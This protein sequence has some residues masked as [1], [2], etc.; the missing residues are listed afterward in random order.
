MYSYTLSLTLALDG[1]SG[2]QCDAPVAVPRQRELLPTVQER[3]CTE[4]VHNIN[5]AI[6]TSRNLVAQSTLYK[7]K[8]SR[9]RPG[10]AQRVPGS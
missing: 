2:D 6:V 4:Y 5:V 9:Y 3:R 10:V 8:Q 1:G 7:V